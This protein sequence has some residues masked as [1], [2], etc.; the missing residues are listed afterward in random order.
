MKSRIGLSRATAFVSP[1][2]TERSL[3]V[4]SITGAP[5]LARSQLVE[6]LVRGRRSV[7]SVVQLCDEHRSG[8]PWRS[9]RAPFAV[10][11]GRDGRP[12]SSSRH[13]DAPLAASSKRP[14]VCRVRPCPRR[15]GSRA[16]PHASCAARRLDW[17]E[18]G[19]ERQRHWSSYT[20][21]APATTTQ[22]P[23][24]DGRAWPLWSG[25]ACGRSAPAVEGAAAA[26]ASSASAAMTLLIVRAS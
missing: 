10:A 11:P 4:S 8:G 9:R 26:A 18:V 16:S 3:S 15:H 23:G 6:P 13:R 17:G 20:G 2:W 24:A 25:P 1:R 22:P 21:A 14:C 12:C 7:L 5:R 19:A